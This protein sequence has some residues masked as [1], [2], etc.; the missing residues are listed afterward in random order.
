MGSQH[1]NRAC[2]AFGSGR[3]LPPEVSWPIPEPMESGCLAGI[4][5]SLVAAEVAWSLP[6]GVARG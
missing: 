2:T 4:A 3:A 1:R 5:A 6:A